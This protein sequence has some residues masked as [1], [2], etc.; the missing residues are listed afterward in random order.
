M[1]GPRPGGPVRSQIPL[2]GLFT[3]SVVAL[4]F[5]ALYLFS[6]TGSS[7]DLVLVRSLGIGEGPNMHLLHFFWFCGF[8]INTLLY[9]SILCMCFCL[10]SLCLSSLCVHL[11]HPYIFPIFV[12]LFLLFLCVCF[13]CLC[14]CDSHFCVSTSFIFMFLHL[15]LY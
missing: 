15:C 7:Y 4:G 8:E 14:V 11:F 12:C 13:F 3:K 2:P 10:S 1:R 5:R 6:V 9:P